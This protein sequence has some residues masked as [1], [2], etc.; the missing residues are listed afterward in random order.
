MSLGLAPLAL[1]LLYACREDVEWLSVRRPTFVLWGGVTAIGWWVGAW[2]FYGWVA[3]ACFAVLWIAGT[4]RGDQVGGLLIGGL[5][6]PDALLA[7]PLALVAAFAVC[8]RRQSSPHALA[9]YPFLSLAVAGMIGLRMAQ[10][11]FT[12]IG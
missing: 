8:W 11:H 9:L 3:L 1:F 6:G 4:G 10:A 2:P 5:L 7:V 12:R